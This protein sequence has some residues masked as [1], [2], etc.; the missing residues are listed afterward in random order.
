[1]QDRLVWLLE[2][3]ELRA[4]V[5]QAGALNCGAEFSA[6]AGLGHLHVLQAG[7]VAI[8]PQGQAPLELDEPSALFFMSPTAHRIRPLENRVSM[9]CATFEFG[10]GEGN[11]LLQALP[12]LTVLRL[13]DAPLLELTMRQLFS[14]AEGAHCGRQGVLD[15]LCEI[16]LILMFRDLMDRRQLEVGLLA[17]LADPQLAQAITV[18]HADPGHNWT[19]EE[20]AQAAGM[21]RARF[22]VRFRDVVGMTPGDYLGEWRVGLAQ[23]MLLKG[24]PLKLVAGDV[25][26]GSASALSRAFAAR[27]G[28]SPTQWLRE[29]DRRARS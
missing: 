5:F 19:L 23:S 26:Y 21:S 2:H 20:L 6:H 8:V 4:R 15:R 11:P 27:R 25:G 3:F 24:K 12:R 29:R 14:E 1:M 9:V 16:A 17:G 28:R 22:A 18:M 13:K 7:R 10:L